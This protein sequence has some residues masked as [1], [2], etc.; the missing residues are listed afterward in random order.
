MLAAL[1]LDLRSN[2]NDRNMTARKRRTAWK[3]MTIIISSYS[4]RPT[5]ICRR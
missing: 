2:N 5:M 4:L 3:D 1:V